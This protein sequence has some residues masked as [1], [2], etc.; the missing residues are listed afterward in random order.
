M[1]EPQ[2]SSCILQS[3]LGL[4]FNRESSLAWGQDLGSWKRF[5]L[6]Q[7]VID[8]KRAEALQRTT[9]KKFPNMN[10]GS[11]W[12]SLIGHSGKSDQSK[13]HPQ[14]GRSEVESGIMGHH[15]AGVSPSK[16]PIVVCS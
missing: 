9:R 6:K 14:A 4:S 15:H 8:M 2:I 16:V 10:T 12:Y 5:L 1:I 7:F 13:L 11:R 3:L